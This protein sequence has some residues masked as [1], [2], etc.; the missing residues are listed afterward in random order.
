MQNKKIAWT[1]LISWVIFGVVIFQ[2]CR[3]LSQLTEG[4]WGERYSGGGNPVTSRYKNY[5]N[6]Q[7]VG[8]FWGTIWICG[9]IGIVLKTFD[10]INRAGT[11]CALSLLLFLLIVIF[12]T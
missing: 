11:V 2:V 12:F 6:A 8:V 1:V 5:T 9:Y 3:E 4:L 10:D 7:L